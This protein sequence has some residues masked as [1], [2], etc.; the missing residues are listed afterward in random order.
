LRR[1]RR[2]VASEWFLLFA[3]T[4]VA[5]I[6]RL[7]ALNRLPPGL[8]HDE[9]YN[10]L[11]AIRVLQGVRPVFFEAN[12]GREPL[13]IYLVALSISFLGRS[14]VAIRL[15][16]ALLGIL[17]IPA[18][19][20]MVREQLGRRQ[21][22]LAAA[23]TAVTFWHL[24]LSR[25]GFRAVSLPFIAAMFLWAFARAMHRNRLGDFALGGLF[26][27]LSLYTY[28]AARFLPIALVVLVAYWLLRRQAIPWRGLLLLSAVA[29]A[30]ALP[31]LLYAWQHLA[32]FLERSAQI[33]ILNPAIN[34]G[35]LVGT[36]ARHL[37]KTGLMFNWRGDFIPRH[38][39]PYRPV[40]DP[41]MGLIFLLGLAIT[42]HR[43]RQEQEYAW[44]FTYWLVMLI[45]TVL[46]EDAPHFLRAVGTL[47]VVFVF[48]AVG[49]T[50]LHERL[51]G[52][53]SERVAR[54]VVVV[55]VAASF[56]ITVN[57]YFARHV[58]SEAA[59]YNFE[60]AAVELASEIN[61]FLGS[62]WTAGPRM[63]SGPAS[64]SRRLYL[65]ERLW[66]DWASLRFLVPD[67][68]NLVILGQDTVAATL[69]DEARVVVWPYAEHGQYLS[70]LP[71]NRLISVRAGP[72]ERGDLEKE[73][74]LL[75]I[76]YS[77]EPADAVPTNLLA[78]FEQGIDLLGYALESTPTGTLLR[79]YW[80]AAQA[81]NVDY[82]VFVHLTQNGQMAEPSDSYPA[83][84]YY[85]THLWRAGDVVADDHS[86]KA[87]L[88][89]GKGYSVAVGLYSLQ[90]MIRLQV[91]APPSGASAGDAVVI[92]FP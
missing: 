84:G 18:T 19:Y 83:Q 36:L 63:P 16:A 73:A 2:L 44:L 77:A 78:H 86:L 26:L 31:L 34:Q 4:V 30:V 75:C 28:L 67:T 55:A 9:A 23:V 41:L 51:R 81:L 14:P 70:L 92:T 71:T 91:L 27:G 33:S 38:N 64:A 88:E 39:L 79:L 89:P 53:T 45:P 43:A 57:D 58:R 76:T 49:L 66:H 15:A 35:E 56:T 21:A 37:I 11:D 6:L 72:L 62:G 52:R 5:A 47:P 90:T 22:M 80:R 10:G 54:L 59:Y 68:P 24:N 46:A 13:F 65:D 74:R 32:T 7:Y 69:A 87:A 29:L 17:T 40:F 8:Y 85:P 20:G 61:G 48:P 82:S 1:F 25:V 60:S 42:L 12:N 3:I 50:W